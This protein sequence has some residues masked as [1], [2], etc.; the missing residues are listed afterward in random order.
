VKPAAVS[1]GDGSWTPVK[2]TSPRYLEDHA[3]RSKIAVGATFVAVI[4]RGLG[5]PPSLSRVV[6]EMA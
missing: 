1:V 3:G 6:S 2:R 5:E 4:V